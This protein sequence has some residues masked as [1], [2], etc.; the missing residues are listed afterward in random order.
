MISLLA[1]RT[2]R[3]R[4]GSADPQAFDALQVRVVG[5]QL[6]DRHT[7]REQ[8]KQI[9]DCVAQPSDRRLAVAD[10]WIRRNALKLGRPE[11]DTP[12][13]RNPYGHGWA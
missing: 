4:D 13:S 10:G 1:G 12:P 9:L 6:V 3:A 2:A 8:L 7:G 5:E 11:N